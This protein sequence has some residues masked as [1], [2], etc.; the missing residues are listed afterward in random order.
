MSKEQ[1]E[2]MGKAIEAWRDVQVIL[3]RMEQISRTLIFENTPGP[4]RR[5]PLTPKV[6]GLI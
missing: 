3:K 6:L 5:K 1:Y 4:S 2:Q